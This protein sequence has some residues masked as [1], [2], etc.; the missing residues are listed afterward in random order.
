MRV[1]LLRGACPALELLAQGG[2]QA[3]GS[4]W[5]KPARGK[6]DI[7]L[8]KNGCLSESSPLQSHL[9]PSLFLVAGVKSAPSFQRRRCQHG[10]VLALCPL[11]PAQPAE[12]LGE[13]CRGLKT[14]QTLGRRWAWR[15]SARSI[16]AAG[17]AMLWPSLPRHCHVPAA[18]GD[19]QD[20]QE[21]EPPQPGAPWH[22]WTPTWPRSWGSLVGCC[23]NPVPQFPPA[24]LSPSHSVGSS[25]LVLNPRD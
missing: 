24:V 17:T 8:I 25:L 18:P 9:P 14:P 2:E 11:L 10:T 4:M 23:Q 22:P 15:G 20:A 21:A 12:P 1:S 13:L 16:P 19:A 6:I 5:G 7:Y 3:K